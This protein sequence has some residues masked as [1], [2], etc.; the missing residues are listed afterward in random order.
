MS[1]LCF[2]I[3]LLLSQKDKFHNHRI[4]LV[5]N[6]AAI[7]SNGEFNRVALRKSGFNLVKIFSPEHGIAA[8]GADGSVQYNTI[9]L[10]T[11]I[12]VI[13]LY[14]D[15]FM[16]TEEDLSDVDIV[17]FDI[18]DVGCRFYTYLWTMTYV[19]EACALYDKPIII[20][21]RPNPI[22]GDIAKS[23]GPLLDEVNCSSFIGRWNI[24]VRHSC[25]LGELATYFADTK[26]KNVNLE[27]KKI[28]NWDRKRTA[29]EAGW[30]FVPTSPAI[31]D[32]ETATLYPG[33]GLLEGIT[34]N[35]GR[36]TTSPFKLVG[37]QW[38]DCE[39]LSEFFNKFKLPGVKTNNI[40]YTPESGIYANQ[41]CFGLKFSITNYD[42]FQPVT[43]GIQLVQ[44]LIL[45]YPNNCKERLY[46]TIANPSGVGHLDKLLGINDSF[47]KL[48]NNEPLS[49]RLRDEDWER[50]IQ[51]Y[52]LY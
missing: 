18:P 5:T 21:D 2:G 51:P 42:S 17:L 9:D 20:L 29:R 12:P 37:A 44:T 43:T 25:T 31:Q 19:I 24:P 35:E 45:L 15:R 11:Q 1:K 23:E 47:E 10:L 28:L 34:V 52:L 22:G 4:A 26:I 27:V 41:V 30:H 46:S 32:K 13:S 50:I 6:D 40:S 14:G 8:K 39:E 16:P 38:I 3:D 49:T 33:M 7:T 48:K 36:G